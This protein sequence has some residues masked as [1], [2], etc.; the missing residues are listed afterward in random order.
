LS[1]QQSA[2]YAFHQPQ[3]GLKSPQGVSVGLLV[4]KLF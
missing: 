2:F 3:T 1:G 4:S